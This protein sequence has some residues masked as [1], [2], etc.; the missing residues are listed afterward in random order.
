MH[1]TQKA[2]F[3]LHLPQHMSTLSTVP[4][5]NLNTVPSSEKGSE[6]D[7]HACHLFHRSSHTHARSCLCTYACSHGQVKNENE[8]EEE[9]RARLEMAAMQ[10]DEKER[11]DQ[12]REVVT[13][14]NTPLGQHCQVG[15]GRL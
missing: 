5:N 12:V 3:V 1:P 14:H 4:Q 11:R 10:A 8:T 7:T 13:T 9:R 2:F 15:Y 6:Q